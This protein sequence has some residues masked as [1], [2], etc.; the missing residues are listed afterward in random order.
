[1]IRIVIA[2]DHQVVRSGLEQLIGTFEDVELVGVACD[3]E[4]AVRICEETHPDITLMD[5]VMP[6]LDGIEA[7]HRIRASLPET[8]VVAFT[9]FSDRERILR[10]LDAGAIGYLLKD[11]EPGELHRGILAAARG[12]APLTPKAAAE[13]LAARGTRPEEGAGLSVR[14]REV[15]VL[16]TRGFANKQI[17]RRLG[18]SE[19]TVKGH[20]TRVFQAIGVS[21]RTQAAL[22]AQRN[23]LLSEED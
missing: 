5:L 12:E 14:E 8:Q 1:M 20:L 11:A 4:E 16:V 2:D 23:G 17:A 21:D 22:W 13:V 19:K 15:L 6:N 3:G 18:I 10:A 7:T 9:S